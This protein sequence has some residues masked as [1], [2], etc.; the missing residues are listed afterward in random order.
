MTYQHTPGPWYV[1]GFILGA[2]GVHIGH[3][4]SH[5]LNDRRD[6]P[7]GYI[8]KTSYKVPSSPILDFAVIS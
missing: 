4:I 6:G 2:P 1:E 8:C 7:A 5:G 3:I